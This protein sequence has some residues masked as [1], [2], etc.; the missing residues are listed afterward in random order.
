MAWYNNIFQSEPNEKI[1][2]ITDVRPGQT[3]G[4]EPKNSGAWGQ[5][6]PIHYHSF[7]GE[8]N[9]ERFKTPGGTQNGFNLRTRSRFRPR[10]MDA[11]PRVSF[12]YFH[13]FRA[14]GF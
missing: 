12:C 8:K 7:D 2:S 14:I 5:W 13:K 4:A 3:S 10:E 6:Q 9:P 1:T 11:R